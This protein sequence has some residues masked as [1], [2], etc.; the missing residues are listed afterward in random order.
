MDRESDKIKLEKENLNVRSEDEIPEEIKDIIDS[1]CQTVGNKL[2]DK[3]INITTMLEIDQSEVANY[4]KKLEPS[5]ESGYSLMLLYEFSKHNAKYNVL[6]GEDEEQF[7][8]NVLYSY[9]EFNIT[10]GEDAM[11]MIKNNLIKNINKIS[12]LSNII[13][14]T[15]NELEKNNKRIDSFLINYDD[16]YLSNLFLLNYFYQK[17]YDNIDELYDS[18]VRSLKT[19]FY[20]NLYHLKQNDKNFV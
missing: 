20:N 1:F 12:N 19:F 17:D 9:G 6:E 7:I 14:F 10:K 2:K 8:K 16:K 13:S 3:I 11:K 18:F 5:N 4:I 15:K